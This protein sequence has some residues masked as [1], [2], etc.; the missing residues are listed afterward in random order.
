MCNDKQFFSI[1]EIADIFVSLDDENKIKVIRKKR[2]SED[3][4]IENTDN[5]AN[6]PSSAKLRAMG[7]NCRYDVVTGFKQVLR[8]LKN[9]YS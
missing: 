2:N 1:S 8:F 7:W 4:Y 3:G 6:L 5:R 9:K